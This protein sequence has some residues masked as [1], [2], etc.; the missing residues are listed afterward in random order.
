MPENRIL[1][2]Y[3]SEVSGHHNATLAIEKALKQLDHRVCVLNIN[4][5]HY[6]NP[7]MEKLINRAYMGVIKRTPRVWDY[8]YDNPRFFKQTQRIKDSIHKSNFKKFAVL[9]EKFK[10]TAVVCTQAFPCG[11]IADYKRVFNVKIPLFGVLTD[12]FPHSY[13]V[14]NEV[15]YYIVPYKEAS[16]RLIKEGIPRERIKQYGIPIDL[17]FAITDH[18][19]ETAKRLGLDLN[20]PTILIMGGGQGLGP[21]KKIVTCLNKCRRDFQ[22]IVVAGTNKKLL[23][24]L[25]KAKKN[26]KHRLQVL[27]Y[28]NNVEQLM[29]VSDFIISKPGGLT[30]AEALAKGL[31]MIIIKPIPGQEEN[32]TQFLLGQGVAIRIKRLENIHIDLERLLGDKEK[33]R[34]MREN[35]RKLGRPNSALDT[36]KLIL[37]A[38]V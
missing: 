17:K 13:W 6:T 36:A 12:F 37:D 21:I 22:L 3:I 4:S 35:A 9:F 34:Q 38:H 11:L 27:E 28:V 2:M 5:F 24:W 25:K 8:L 30:A 32:N 10:P 7:I 16:D 20:I 19:K 26:Y 23:K 18:R 1:L 33:V 31:P 15:D 14:Y 29:E